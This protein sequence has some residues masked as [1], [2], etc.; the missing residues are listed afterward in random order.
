V[1]WYSNLNKISRSTTLQKKKSFPSSLKSEVLAALQKPGSVLT[2]I[3]KSYG[4]SR[5][6]VYNWRSSTPP[7]LIKSRDIIAPKQP[8]FVEL[9]VKKSSAP[10]IQKANLVFENYSL[11]IEGNIKLQNLIQIINILG[12]PC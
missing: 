1:I 9:A 5:S 12:S 6:T 7:L 2:T 3:A 10:S 4:I 11:S 8:S